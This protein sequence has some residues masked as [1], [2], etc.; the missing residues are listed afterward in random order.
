MG[1][2]RAATVSTARPV[3]RALL[4]VVACL[5][6]YNANLRETS[7]G[8]TAGV[9]LLPAIIVLE[10]R[11]HLDSF[12]RGYPPSQ[13]PPYWAQRANGHYRS[14][15]PI[16]PA[17]LAVPVYALPVYLFGAESWAFVNLLSKASASLFAAL[18][19]LFVYLTIRRLTPDPPALRIAAVYAVGTSTWSIASQGLWG[20]GPAQ[21]FLA[22]ALYATLRADADPRVFHAVGLATG[23]MV[24]TRPGT[25]LMAL[26]LLAYVWHRDRRAGCWSAL[27]FATVAL[28][29]VWHNLATF[30]SVGG[31][32]AE[33]H[34]TH[35]T[36]HGVEGAFASPLGQGLL[37]L[38][39][40]PSRGLLVYSPV[41]L[42][43]FAGMLLALVAR[44]PPFYGYL[45]A[46]LLAS[47]LMLGK[48]S[49]W[50][51]GQSF[52]PRL[53]TD[54]LP[55]L[56]VFLVPVLERLRG[57]RLGQAAFAS[58][59]AL[60]VAV[61]VVGA[62]YYPSR[63]DVDWNTSPRDVDFAHERLWDWRDP[64]LLRLLANGPRPPG[65]G[66]PPP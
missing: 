62:F 42:F 15:Y 13:E 45:A 63:R 35:A 31:G 26:A 48:Y 1:R 28:A 29:V 23:L 21:L 4:L 3:R 66:L 56:V 40:S 34:A 24:A 60:S 58:L 20:H 38:L 9:R 57:A 55:A 44:R 46:G 36:R 54:F 43:A 59:F 64:Q 5:L 19:V 27:L 2:V 16:L 30:G 51:G 17:L 14:S 33:L 18:S 41:L 39:V 49:V 22:A 10:H 65:F 11:L 61:Q 25:A 7:S 6:I 50:W 52:G 37:G 12:F 47:L 8:D 53:P 32:Y